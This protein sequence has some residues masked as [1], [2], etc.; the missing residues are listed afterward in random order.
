MSE[1]IPAPATP[2]PPPPSTPSGMWALDKLDAFFLWAFNA[3]AKQWLARLAVLVVTF[4]MSK[5]T[6]NRVEYS[7]GVRDGVVVKLAEK[8]LV[9]GTYEGT[10]AP[11]GI[12]SDANGNATG[13]MS[14]EPFQ[15]SV[16]L[17]DVVE[18]LKAL[19][20]G[21]RVRL[22][23]SEKLLEWSP[24]GHTDTYVTKVEPLP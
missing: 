22:H 15:F 14:A 1:P 23:F 13:V 12:G 6:L 2:E 3:T 10:L 16:N 20:P 7:E 8:G 4:L 5:V 17:P 24:R 21:Q 9:F 11:G 19:K 18:Q